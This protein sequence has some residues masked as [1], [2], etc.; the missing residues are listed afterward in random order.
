M[1]WPYAGLVSCCHMSRRFLVD[2]SASTEVSQVQEPT[3]EHS[4][5]DRAVT[6][7]VHFSSARLTLGLVDLKEFF[8]PK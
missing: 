6:G 7:T 3:R 8:Q 5:A 4:A 2:L 1:L